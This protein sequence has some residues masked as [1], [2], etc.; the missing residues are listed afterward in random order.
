MLF[1]CVPVLWA[2]RGWGL[3]H[4]QVLIEQAQLG[5]VQQVVVLLPAAVLVL[6]LVPPLTAAPPVA[7][8]PARTH[9]QTDTNTRYILCISRK[10]KHK[11]KT[12]A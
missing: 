5:E 1:I 11:C 10:R 8:Q 7:H 2:S 9:T 4:L 12:V 3:T 6:R